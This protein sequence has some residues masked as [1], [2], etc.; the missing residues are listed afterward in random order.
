MW[1]KGFWLGIR[2][3]VVIGGTRRR[4]RD[5]LPTSSPLPTAPGPSSHPAAT[6]PRNKSHAWRRILAALK[7]AMASVN[8]LGSRLRS[9]MARACCRCSPGCAPNR[10]RFRRGTK[11]SAHRE[12]GFRANLSRQSPDCDSSPLFCRRVKGVPSSFVT[13]PPAAVTTACPAAVSHSMV[14]PRRGIEDRLR[15]LRSRQNLRD[16][17]ADA[18]CVH[19]FYRPRETRRCLVSPWLRLITA[20]RPGRQ[21][22]LRAPM[23]RAAPISSG[24]SS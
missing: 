8:D 19:R 14:G 4:N 15:R 23:R 7:A 2:F 1:P 20:V 3:G 9:P 24:T 6:R 16:D 22:R 18:R 11:S 21:A 12:A 13:V 10:A 5:G 17:P